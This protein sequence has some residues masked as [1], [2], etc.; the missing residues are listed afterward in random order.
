M[1]KRA[2]KGQIIKKVNTEDA[3]IRAGSFYL[4]VVLEKKTVEFFNID[5]IIVSYLPKNFIKNRNQRSFNEIE[6]KENFGFRK[7]DK[8]LY[9][10]FNS[11]NLNQF[12]ESSIDDSSSSN[13]LFRK[14]YAKNIVSSF[15]QDDF[16]EDITSINTN[17]DEEE[18]SVLARSSIDKIKQKTCLMLK[19][20]QLTPLEAEIGKVSKPSN[21]ILLN[22]DSDEELDFK[23]CYN[24]IIKVY[25]V[26]KKGE[27]LDKLEIESKSIDK[28][29][30]G[31]Q[32]SNELILESDIELFVS[33]FDL[34]FRPYL[35]PTYTNINENIEIRG[36]V[37]DYNNTILNSIFNGENIVNKVKVTLTSNEISKS[38]NL[39]EFTSDLQ[40]TDDRQNFSRELIENKNFS[41]FILESKKYLE[42]SNKDSLDIE[43]N[44]NIIREENEINSFKLS[45]ISKTIINQ[46]YQNILSYNFEKDLTSGKVIKIEVDKLNRNYLESLENIYKININIDIDNYIKEQI[47]QN[48]ISFNFFDISGNK[49]TGIDKFYF[50]ESTLDSN[51]ITGPLINLE[52]LFFDQ[53]T[54][55]LYIEN[56]NSLEQNLI[57]NCE[58]LFHSD[59]SVEPISIGNY[60]VNGISSYSRRINTSIFDECATIIGRNTSTGFNLNNHLYNILITRSSPSESFLLNIYNILGDVSFK[61]AGYFS[62]SSNETE[63][64]RLQEVINNTLVKVTKSIKINNLELNE[65]SGYFFLNEITDEISSDNKK[66]LIDTSSINVMNFDIQS[67]LSTNSEIL[68]N[69]N[70][71]TSRNYNS[72]SG[73]FNVD[74]KVCLDFAVLK[75]NTAIKFGN[76]KDNNQS[77]S[78]LIEFITSN[79]SN[80]EMSRITSILSNIYSDIFFENKRNL[81]E[82]IYRSSNILETIDF[83]QQINASIQDFFLEAQEDTVDQNDN[84]YT[85]DSRKIEDFNFVNI[86]DFRTNMFLDFSKNKFLL[87]KKNK[88]RKLVSIKGIDVERLIESYNL[89]ENS[90]VLKSF[91]MLEYQFDSKDF[92]NE[93]IEFIDNL[94]YRIINSNIDSNCMFLLKK[95]QKSFLPINLSFSNNSI[96]IDI[97]RESYDFEKF[98][99][100]LY[101]DE[102]TRL[103]GKSNS[104]VIKNITLR[105]CISLNINGKHN[106]LLFNTN[107][108]PSRKLIKYIRRNSSI[109]DRNYLN[110]DLIDQNK[111]IYKP[112]IVYKGSAI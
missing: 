50:D 70:S 5:K 4:P 6:K 97:S 40:S 25:A 79:N 88:E 64:E 37:L 104:L 26:N 80:F 17:I 7:Q 1:L 101:Y 13:K 27:V 14:I 62:S 55:S 11:K 102:A 35:Y 2:T 19:A 86:E 111:L 9:V 78:N 100:N 57:Q 71:I 92:S 110:L 69:Y 30:E 53:K 83:E 108:Q 98:S 109:P 82:E 105:F 44:F 63:S 73:D 93:E 90:S 32:F 72:V 66:V 34:T 68:N 31:N 84:I 21:E 46:L 56:Q 74:Y 43:Y 52:N 76:P 91:C 103:V 24:M 59:L 45:S 23:V 106:I 61:N 18:I 33:D 8:P 22:N 85:S 12:E 81:I 36:P 87:K 58:L 20:S 41:D 3:F 96:F 54:I 47:V 94:G 75:N 51:S 16:I 112:S 28:Y 39:I 49:I 95:E 67:K 89:Y 60:N 48:S 99:S 107:L 65:V 10:K 42:E 29:S 77:K 15:G 38:L